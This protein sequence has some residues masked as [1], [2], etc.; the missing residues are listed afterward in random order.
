ML[1]GWLIGGRAIIINKNKTQINFLHQV[2]SFRQRVSC[3]VGSAQL[4]EER[5]NLLACNNVYGLIAIATSSGKFC[6]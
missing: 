5:V 1:F 4:P 6:R 3:K 2:L